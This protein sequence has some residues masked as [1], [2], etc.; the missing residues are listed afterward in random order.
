MLYRLFNMLF[1][2]GEDP[3]REWRSALI[4]S[5]DVSFVWKFREYVE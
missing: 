3:L 2:K 1:L 4:S 5:Q